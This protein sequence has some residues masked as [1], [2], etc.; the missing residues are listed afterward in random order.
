VLFDPFALAQELAPHVAPGDV[1]PPPP[2]P[3]GPTEVLQL[4]SAERHSPGEGSF[5]LMR[6]DRLHIVTELARHGL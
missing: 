5:Y 4:E 6:E 3:P 2:G 1:D